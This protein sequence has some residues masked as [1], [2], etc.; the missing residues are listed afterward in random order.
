MERTD[1]RN[2]TPA[3]L[4]RTAG[5]TTVEPV[6]TLLADGVLTE[7]LALAVPEGTR[8]AVANYAIAP[9]GSLP[10]HYHEGRVVAVV[11]AGVL[12]RTLADGSECVTPA[13]GCIV[14]PVGPQ[15]V[16]MAENREPEPLH[17]C[18]LFFLPQGSALSTRAEPPEA[19]AY[20]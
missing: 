13:G 10:W 9:G 4:R 5:P 2:M 17:I 6:P 7:E 1:Q 16:H 8:V 11:T 20:G 3:R 12:T 19:L 14:E 18:A 15:G